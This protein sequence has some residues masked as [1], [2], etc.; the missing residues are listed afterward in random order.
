MSG[1]R[2]SRV[3]GTSVLALA[4][5]TRQSQ[6]SNIPLLTCLKVSWMQYLFQKILRDFCFFGGKNFMI[7]FSV[8]VP[9]VL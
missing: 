7:F 4:K 9:C 8:I 5:I 6:E 3:V 2:E 1:G